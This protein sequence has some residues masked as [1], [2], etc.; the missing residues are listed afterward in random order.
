MKNERVF[1]MRAINTSEWNV[2]VEETINDWRN[3]LSLLML[4]DKNRDMLDQATIQLFEAFRHKDFIVD[5][6]AVP[7]SRYLISVAK[8]E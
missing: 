1:E 5:G 4:D 3:Y 2:F 6:K 7:I 8:E